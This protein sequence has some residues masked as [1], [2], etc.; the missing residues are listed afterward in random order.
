[1]TRLPALLAALLLLS[2]VAASPVQ[3][4]EPEFATAKGQSKPVYKDSVV[5]EFRIPSP[6]GNLYGWVRRPVVP[7]GVEVPVILTYSPYHLLLSQAPGQEP[8]GSAIQNYFVP[9]GYARAW[10]H[11]VGTG[12][13]EGCYDYGGARDVE[14]G[15]QVVEWLAGRD[16]A[17]G[18]VGMI[19]GS[20]DGTTQ[21]AAAIAQ[22]PSLKT[23]VPQVAIDRWYDYAHYNGVRINSGFGGTPNLFDLGFNFGLP[24][25]GSGQALADSVRPCEAIEHNTRAYERDA[26]YDGF[27]DQRDYRTRAGDIRASVMIEGSWTDGNVLPHNSLRMWRGLRPGLL[28]RFVMGLQGH[29]SNRLADAMDV[30]HAWFDRELLGLD[31]GVEK[32]PAVDSIDVGTK[33][34]VQSAAWPPPETRTV[35]LDLGAGTP[36]FGRLTLKDKAARWT[37][38]NP[39]LDESDVFAGSDGASGI[40]FTGEPV[41]EAVRIV[42]EVELDLPLS[43]NAESTHVQAVLFAEDPQGARKRIV[44]GALNSR[45]RASERVNEPFP[46]TGA[47]WRARFGLLPTDYVLPAGHRLGLALMSANAS[48]TPE[49]Y[50]DDTE[51][52][53]TVRLE[54]AP[55][56]RVPV[57]TGAPALGTIE[58]EPAPAGDDRPRTAPERVAG[59]GPAPAAPATAAAPAAPAACVSRRGFSRF[60]VRATRDGGLSVAVRRLAARPFTFSLL[61]QATARGVLGTDLVFR[62]TGSRERLRVAG[63]RLADG[64]YLA[65]V[66]TQVPGA[67]ADVR[68][69]YLRRAGGRFSV[70]PTAYSRRSCGDV[71]S[72]F[73]LDRPVFGG[74]GGRA[75]GIAYRLRAPADRVEVRVLGRGGRTLAGAATQAGRTIRLRLPA[76]GIP[77]GRDVRIAI[78]VVRGRSTLTET[79]TARRL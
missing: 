24:D 18:R 15:A 72:S 16:W 1:M 13:S 11:V 53:N 36:G 64:F 78:T 57:S 56:L 55:R 32:L 17:N 39:L 51:A 76:R 41:A 25:P 37:D 67:S 68:R 12:K 34:R 69:I 5:E 70:R 21:F 22:P 40:V 14:T 23:I 27:W 20:Y 63:R 10:F 62:R 58:A 30:R 6:H 43:T 50:S 75:L 74:P 61:R 66:R 8:L 71:L 79:L 29:G 26:T 38:A 45:M 73:K 7:K 19:G 9:R 28:K 47:A 65:R 44:R 2:L 4:Q 46:G 3:A 59:P 35:A 33:K 60:A 48:F 54:D 42:D 31:T 49:G 77:R 52:T